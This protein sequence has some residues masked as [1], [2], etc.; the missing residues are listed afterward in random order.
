MDY[1]PSVWGDHFIKHLADDDET[2]NRRKKEHEELKEEVRKLLVAPSNKHSEKLNLIDI[3]LRLGIGY[4]FEGEIERVLE[5][6]YNSYQDYHEEDEDLHTVALRFRL[7]RQQGYNDVKGN[8][9]G[10]IMNDAKGLLSLYEALYLR[11]HGED[12]LDEALAFTKTHLKLMLPRLDSILG[13]LVAHAL[14]RPL[15][16]D[17]QRHAHY[18]FIS[19]Y[20]QDEA[21]NPA[22]LKLAKLDFNHLQKLYQKELNALTKWWLELDFKRKLPFARDRMVETYFW[23]LGAFF[24]P[25]FATA[26]LML[27]KATALV[28]YED[29]I[30]DAYGTIEELELFTETVRRWDTSAQGLPEYLRV[31]FD[32]VIGFVN[33]VKEHTVKE[34]RS[35][36]EFFIKEAEK[37]QTQSHLTEARWLSDNYVP[38]LEEYRRNGVYSSTY[39]L[40]AAA[41]FCGLGELGSKEVFEWL[42][43]DPKIMVASSD[44]AR[45]IDD[46]IGHETANRRKKEHEELKEEVR[47]LLV[48]PSNKHSEK[49]NLIDIILRLGIGYHFEGEIERVLEQVYNSY[50]DYH[51]EDED[52]H[53]VALRFRLLRQQGYNVS[54]EVFNNFKDVKGNFEGRIMN[55][56]KGLLSLYEALYLRVHGEDILDE[57][58]AFTK[59][60]LKLMLPQLD[61]ILG[62]LQDEAHNPALLKLAKLDFNHLQKLYQKEL[63]ALSKWWLELDFKRKLPFARDR[64]VETYFWALGAFFEPQFATA[65]CM[66]TKATALVSYED[67]IYDA[68]GTIEELELFTET[69]KRW[70]TSAQGLPEY[71]R[72]FFDAVIG[73]VNDVKEHT[74][75]EGRSYCEFFIKEAEKNQ[76]QSHLTEARWLSDNY[77]P[78]LEE[79]RRNGVYSSTY[80]LLAAA[81]FCGLGELGSKEVFEWLLNDPKIM[82]ASSDLARLIDDVIGHEFEQQRQHVASSVECY[83]KQN[84]V[85]K[86]KAYEEL[87]KLIESDWKDLNEELLKQAAFPKQVLAVFL[88]LA[89]VMVVLYKDFDGYTEARTR[90]KD[91]L[92]AL[93]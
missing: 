57:A 25:Q 33:D 8:F 14:E 11:V 74:V 60:H 13:K 92:E 21:H 61:S 16:R 82:V 75:K 12:I 78:T 49:L 24:E 84:G 28:S 55:D 5:Q 89:R 90:T 45:L 47:K 87:N 66:L 35:Y 73:F 85:S 29:D 91:M 10:R 63:N 52:L 48:A 36:C 34:G 56:A 70:D 83:M 6:V 64:M 32:A 68:Y 37:N 30:Y 53:T 7:L 41:T 2:A 77:V 50:Q 46:V 88:N 27:T 39:P 62:K 18:H 65:R 72:V 58:L 80:P 59:S 86:Q 19:I 40:L 51:E 79:Y 1:H 44:L 9:E 42:L 38:T 81:T 43:N 17:V 71:L 22:L 4:H 93:I 31:F 54:C 3:I 69:V 15:Y 23:A 67:D 20:Q 76:T 26:R